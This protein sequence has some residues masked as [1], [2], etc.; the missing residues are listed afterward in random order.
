MSKSS[1]NNKRIAKNTIYLYIRSAIVMVITLFTTRITL[2]HLGVEDYGLYNVVGGVVGLFAFLRTSM[3]KSTQRYLNVEMVNSEGKLNEVFCTSLNIHIVIAI[4]TFIIC[5]TIGL[6]FL[7]TYIQIPNGRELA[8]NVIYQTT[9]LTLITTILSVPYSADII[10]HEEMGFFAVVSIVDAVIKLLIAYLIA[11]GND[12]LILYAILMAFVSVLNLM[13]YYWYCRKHYDET[14][15]HF[16]RNKQLVKSM[17]GYTS[18]TV[19]GQF[20][21]IGTNQGNN[22][23][24]NIFHSVTAN[25]AMGV[26][27]Q[28]NGAITTLTSNFQTAFNPQITKSFALKD[29]EY[30]KKLVYVT[31]KFS[32]LLLVTASLP[33]IFNI[34][35]ILNIWLAEV[36]EYAAEFCVLIICSTILNA[37]GAP[38]NFTALSSGDIKWFQIFTAIAFLLDLVIVYPL[39][40]MGFPAITALVV[41]VFSMVLVTFVRV[42]FAHRVVNN[43]TV[44]TFLCDV[45]FPLLISTF[46]SVVFGLF[47]FHFAHAIYLKIIATLLLLCASMASSYFISLTTVERQ[48][49]MKYVKHFIHKSR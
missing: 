36:P 8:A 27:G 38:F 44:K 47:V 5:E 37:L 21:I 11:F 2:K 1:L 16:Y 25:A 29:Y 13:M 23:L 17:L 4:C 45:L 40:R 19:V 43:I 9:I 41:K 32:C 30:L 6:W 46:I 49:L 20:A 14:K 7:N 22:I 33:I 28:V 24:M 10:A 48:L 42:Y 26:A 31:S 18:W 34:D 3:T 12:R 39:F 35:W 15:Y